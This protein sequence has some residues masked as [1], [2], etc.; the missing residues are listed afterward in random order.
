MLLTIGHLRNENQYINL[1]LHLEPVLPL[2]LERV[3][4]L[5]PSAELG[6]IFH[7][8][9]QA[10]GMIENNKTSY[11]RLPQCKNKKVGAGG[12]GVQGQKSSL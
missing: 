7:A 6:K 3:R 12:G 4:I 9:V 8:P 1:T 10:E 5:S 11:T 2:K